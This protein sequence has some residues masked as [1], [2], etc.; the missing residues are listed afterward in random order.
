MVKTPDICN[1]YLQMYL[2]S[3][4]DNQLSYFLTKVRMGKIVIHPLSFSL[5]TNKNKI[6][7]IKEKVLSTV[8]F[9]NAYLCFIPPQ[10]WILPYITIRREGLWWS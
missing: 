1:F 9:L 3:L 4:K 7:V 10:K 8:L 2:K 6:L 5:G